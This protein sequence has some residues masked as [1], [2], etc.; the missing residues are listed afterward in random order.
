MTWVV[1]CNS[2]FGHSYLVSD[3]CVTFTL[4]SGEKRYLDCLQ[5]VYPLGKF[6][7]GGFA[8]SVQIGLSIFANLQLE[9]S[10][11]TEGNAWDL[12]IVVNTWFPRLVRRI[13]KKC[14][15]NEQK[16]GSQILLAAAH[17]HKNRG[18]S[19]WAIT[20]L[21]QFDSPDFSPQKAKPDDV[22]SIG[23]GSNVLTYVDAIK[24]SRDHFSFHESI[25]GGELS[26][27]NHFATGVE[28]AVKANPTLGVSNFFQIAIVSRGKIIIK[29]HEYDIIKSNRERIEVRCP[30]IAKNMEEFLGIVKQNGMQVEVAIC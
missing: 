1:G 29:N 16:L 26:Q 23:S 18:E 4:S 27:S 5:K 6:I 7:I 22:F 19:P 24:Q 12:G 21:F 15:N 20:D 2:I 30:L 17:P 3:V 28:R 14:P 9:F 25:I 10:N 13:F 8:G 11:V